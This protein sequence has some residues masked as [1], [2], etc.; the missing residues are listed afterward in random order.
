VPEKVQVANR[1][2]QRPQDATNKPGNVPGEVLGASGRDMIRAANGESDGSSGQTW[3][4]G[5]P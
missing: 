3:T 2:P 5:N 1:V 4:G